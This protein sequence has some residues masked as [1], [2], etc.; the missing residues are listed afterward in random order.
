VI[1]EQVAGHE[2]PLALG[3]ED[4]ELVHLVLRLE[5]LGGIPTLFASEG[6]ATWLGGTSGGDY[7]AAVRGLKEYLAENPAASLESLMESSTAPQAVRYAAGAVV[8]AM[9]SDAGGAAAL[10]QFLIAGPGAADRRA[11][12]ERLLGKSWQ[13]LSADWR[14]RVARVES[15]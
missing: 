11:V 9:V 2:H 15:R 13:S 7:A 4:H 8:S 5:H 6:V 10:K 12:L 1:E 3:R 14:A